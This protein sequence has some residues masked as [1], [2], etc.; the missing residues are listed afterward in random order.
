MNSASHPVTRAFHPAATL[1]YYQQCKN[2]A[3]PPYINLNLAHFAMKNIRIIAVGGGKG[4]AKTF[5]KFT[6]GGDQKSKSLTLKV[7]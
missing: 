2:I 3:F 1:L 5:L 4:I 6:A 7:E